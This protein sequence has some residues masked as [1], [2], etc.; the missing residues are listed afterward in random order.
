MKIGFLFP[1]QGS[2]SLEMGKELYENYEEIRKVYNRV[3]EITGMDIAEITFRGKEETLNQTNNTQICILTMSLAILALLEK[4]EIKAEVSSGLSLGEYTALIDSKVLDFEEGIKLV[5]KRGEY[6][7]NL[8]PQGEWA[9]AAILG[10]KDEE[11]EKIC[12]KIQNGFVVPVNYNCPGQI[13]VSGDRKAVE[14]LGNLAKEAGAKKVRIL[15]TAGPFHTEKLTEAAH[16][17]K[18]ELEKVT[19]HPFE[20]IVVKNI[21]GTPYQREEP[22]KEILANHMISPVKFSK[23]NGYDR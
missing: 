20:T 7:Q 18:K 4:N 5:Q 12:K 10:L 17:F 11:V 22:I 2:Q 8:V 16:Q 23:W 6:M 15:N 21:D 13:V 14:D 1:G 3:K 9:M 19:I